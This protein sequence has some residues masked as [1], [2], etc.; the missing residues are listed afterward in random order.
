M[1]PAQHYL[2]FDAE[3]VAPEVAAADKTPQQA[4]APQE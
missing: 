2:V 3:P 1:N 4:A